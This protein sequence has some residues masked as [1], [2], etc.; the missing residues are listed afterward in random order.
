MGLSTHA[1]EVGLHLLTTQDSGQ[2]FKAFNV[3]EIVEFAN[4]YYQDLFIQENQLIQCLYLGGRRNGFIDRQVIE[5][6]FN[7][8]L[9]KQPGMLLIMKVDVMAHPMLITLYRSG[10]VVSANDGLA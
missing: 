9:I 4:L 6:G 7:V 8:L 3:P 5:K 2:I 10:T 1:I